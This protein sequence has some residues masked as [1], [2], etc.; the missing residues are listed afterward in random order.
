MS[1]ALLPHRY[2]L[3]VHTDAVL[4]M[5]PLILY[6]MVILH[7]IHKYVPVRRLLQFPELQTHY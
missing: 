5:A 3:T 1:R 7:T 4:Y 2:L 6:T